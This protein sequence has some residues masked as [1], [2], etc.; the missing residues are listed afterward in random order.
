M[1]LSRLILN[2]LSRQVQQDVAHPYQMHCTVMSA[3]PDDLD[4]E[5][6][7]ILW[8]VDSHRR[9]GALHLLV[10]SQGEPDWGW[11]DANGQP[12]PYLAP[13]DARNPAVKQVDLQFD[14]GQILSFRLFANPTKRLGKTYGADKGK[15]VGIYRPEDQL[16]WL[17]RKAADAGFSVLSATLN[18]SGK[19]QDRTQNLE[20]FGIRFDGLL[21][22]ADPRRLVTAIN[23]GIGSGKAFGF[24]LL[25][26]APANR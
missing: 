2:S 9:T 5:T 20:L 26:V 24:G 19:T 23:Q 7:R 11:L 25:S 13:V 8:R 22:V 12:R 6:E 1:Y 10:Q 14:P 16:S 3:F 4:T 15:R 18:A 17:D 21:Q